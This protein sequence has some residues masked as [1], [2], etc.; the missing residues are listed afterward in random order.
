MDGL[1]ENPIRTDDLGVPLFSETSI[2][3][4]S[5]LFPKLKPR[6]GSIRIATRFTRPA[7]KVHPA[8]PGGRK[9]TTQTFPKGG[10]LQGFNKKH[11]SLLKETKKSRLRFFGILNILN[12]RMCV[13]VC[14]LEFAKIRFLYTVIFNWMRGCMPPQ[15]MSDKGRHGCT[16][17]K[18]A[19]TQI[20]AGLYLS[21]ARILLRIRSFFLLQVP[22]EEFFQLRNAQSWCKRR[23]AKW[24]A[25]ALP[26]Q[27][28][29]TITGSRT[30]T[31]RIELMS[32]MHISYKNGQDLLLIRTYRRQRLASWTMSKHWRRD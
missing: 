29:W 26:C 5:Y 6:T 24:N 23:S 4:L 17:S 8:Q 15:P 14:L 3:N 25:A 9:V 11:G 13:C 2:Y 7:A 22:L 32:T 31:K 18:C 27:W 30:E 16:S 1:M 20:Y 10:I 12:V 19:G 21:F 28:S